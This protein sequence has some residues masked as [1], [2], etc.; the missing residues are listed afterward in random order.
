MGI[1]KRVH[2]F[3]KYEF[4][5]KRHINEVKMSRQTSQTD[6][7]K[8]MIAVIHQTLHSGMWGMEFDKNGKM[9]E[10]KWSDEFRKMLGYQNTTDFPNELSSWSDLLHKDD[11]ERVIKEFMDTINDYTG[12]KSYD[13]KYRLITK[14]GEWRHYHAMGRLI[15]R[16]NGA[17]RSY[18]GLFVDITD[19]VRQEQLLHEALKQAEAANVA[20]T[21][22][23]SSMS[24]DIRTPM[25]GI[26][27]MTAIAGSHI[28]DKER[29]LDCL[30]KITT[31][32]KH[33]LNL[34]NEVLDMSKIESG[35]IDMQ[36]DPLFLPDL[37][38]NLI[39]MVRPQIE[40]HG[41]ELEVSIQNLIHENVLGDSLR[42]Q[43]V[44]VNLM[45]NAIKYTPDGGNISLSIAEKTHPGSKAG[46][47]EFVFE[48]NGIGM[49]E[50]YVKKIFEPFSRA[51]D[52]RTNNI[53]GTGLGMT[54]TQNI[55][56]MMGGNIR[57]ES[58][59]NE[60][61]RITVTIFLP[62]S[63]S[64][65]INEKNF[66]DL[67]ILVA[68]DDWTVG[69]SASQML[70]SLG[71]KCQWVLSGKDAL[72]KVLEA[73]KKNEDFFAVI[74]DWKMP[75]MD[76]VETTR[77]IRKAVGDEIP[78]IIISAYDW[79]DIE[80]EAR[81]AGAT[82]FISKPLFRSRLARLFHSLLQKE[83]IIEETSALAAFEDLKLEGKHI[84]LAEDNE[85]NAEIAKEVLSSTGAEV[86][87]AENGR[88]VLDRIK[89]KPEGYYDL[90]FMDIRMPVMNG[91]EAS[92]AIRAAEGQYPREIPIIAMTADAF[93]ED[94]Q[95]A[96]EAGMNEHVAKPL[97]LDALA[98]VLYR[99]LAAKDRKT[100]S[101][102]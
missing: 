70:C 42:I 40:S 32:S 99:Y 43:Q 64:E 39:N 61:T 93:A 67:P 51:E 4:L 102:A 78:I 58:Q 90:I 26:I 9:T 27:G 15:R 57:V 79:S 48:D 13:V 66:I 73:H 96:K 12:Q 55:V 17:P 35:K 18:I 8:T 44:F 7:L 33:L 6:Y 89:E 47:F 19:D 20:K 31:A 94:V 59:I 63:K 101:Q 50:E 28:D 82:A 11:R 86:D 75:E 100:H 36:S 54:I 60:G 2:K 30:R 25:N 14:T 83:D 22:F 74:V 68:D 87:R 23:L 41:H 85:L 77:A 56:R 21:E 71:M 53:Q 5:K 62:I 52:T 1:N 98:S 88:L 16:E 49:T 92:R 95:A 81:K 76:G 37:I 46:C 97:D 91:Y 34:I 10:V 45:G 65:D 80:D 84:L 24:H 29:V 72:E 38:D 69:E 3:T